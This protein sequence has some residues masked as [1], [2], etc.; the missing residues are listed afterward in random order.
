MPIPKNELATNKILNKVKKTSPIQQSD[1]R[2]KPYL[3]F[4]GT[5]SLLIVSIAIQANN[6]AVKKLPVMAANTKSFTPISPDFAKSKAKIDAR[7]CK[8]I[9]L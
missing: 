3:F 7:I 9:Q 8:T 6:G 5:N 2:N 1:R 4:W